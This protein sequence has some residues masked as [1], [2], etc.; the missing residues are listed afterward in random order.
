MAK[1]FSET[2]FHDDAHF[3]ANP[4]HAA[5]RLKVQDDVEKQ[6]EHLSGLHNPFDPTVDDEKYEAVRK[7]TAWSRNTNEY[8]L[9]KHRADGDHEIDYNAKTSAQHEEQ[10]AHISS[11]IKELGERQPLEHETHVYSGIRNF[12][13]E[14]VFHMPA[15]TSTSIDP[16]VANKFGNHTFGKEKHIIHFTLPKG[17]TKG[18]YLGQAVSEHE[19]EHEYLLDKDQKFKLTHKTEHEVTFMHKPIKIHCW[20]VTPVDH[21]QEAFDHTDNDLRLSQTHDSEPLEAKAHSDVIETHKDML[22]HHPADELTKIEHNAVRAHTSKSEGVNS[23]LLAGR[24]YDDIIIGRHIKNVMSAIDKAKPLHRD[25]HVYSGLGGFNPMK[26]ANDGVFHTPAFIST[27]INPQT[28]TA[29]ANH[30][31]KYDIQPTIGKFNKDTDPDHILHVHLPKGYEGGRYIAG[32]SV[33]PKEHEFLLAPN[34]HYKITHVTEMESPRRNIYHA[35]PYYRLGMGTMKESF[36][37]WPSVFSYGSRQERAKPSAGADDRVKTHLARADRDE[38]HKFLSS[39]FEHVTAGKPFSALEHNNEKED[40]PIHNYVF[41]SIAAAINKRCILHHN[42]YQMLKKMKSTNPEHFAEVDKNHSFDEDVGNP[43]PMK[44]SGTSVNKLSASIQENARPL[45]RE[46]HFYSA[47]SSAHSSVLRDTAGKGGVVHLPAFTSTTIDPYL[48]RTWSGSDILHFHLPAGYNK[49][50][51]IGH[52]S[53]M[54]HEYEFLLDKAQD[55]H[56]H[57]VHN[58]PGS[59]RKLWTLKPIEHLNETYEYRPKAFIQTERGYWGSKPKLAAHQTLVAGEVNQQNTELEAAM[60]TVPSYDTAENSRIHQYTNGRVSSAINKHLISG[61]AHDAPLVS[62]MSHADLQDLAEFKGWN[63]DHLGSFTP[64]HLSNEIAEHGAPL[65]HET[66]VYSGMKNFDPTEHF[67]QHG[68][69][70]LPAFT[71]TSIDPYIA[72]GFA[73]HEHEDTHVLHMVVPKGYSKGVYLGKR[74]TYDNEKEY[75]LDKG[76]KWDFVSKRVFKKIKSPPDEWGISNDNLGGIK[77]THVWTVKPHET[78]LHEALTHDAKKYF[79]QVSVGDNF[80]S[81]KKT[82]RVYNSVKKKAH[83]YNSKKT[84]HL[85]ATKE[86][87]T[88]EHASVI[89]RQKG[90]FGHLDHYTQRDYGEAIRGYKGDDSTTFN[91]HLIGKSNHDVGDA[92]VHD[93]VKKSINDLTSAIEHAPALDHETHVYSGISGWDPS[94]HLANGVIHTPAFTSTSFHPTVASGF[95]NRHDTYDGSPSNEEMHILHFHLPAGYKEG[96]AIHGVSGG[97]HDTSLGEQEDD[98][99]KEYV[100]NRGQSWK[101][102]GKQTVHQTAFH[103]VK[104]QNYATDTVPKT[105]RKVHVWTLTPHEHQ[106]PKDIVEAYNHDEERAVL[107]DPSA[108]FKGGHSSQRPEQNRQ[109]NELSAIFPH[110][111]WI[112]GPHARKSYQDY[113]GYSSG[114]NKDLIHQHAGFHHSAENIDRANKLS[115]HIAQDTK[116][117]PHDVHV[118]SGLGATFPTHRIASEGEIHTPAFVSASLNSTVAA[119]FA[120]N[121]A[122]DQ[123]SFHIA[124]FHL[125]AGYTKGIYLDSAPVNE[126]HDWVEGNYNEREYLLDKDQ[127]WKHTGTEKIVRP[128]NSVVHVHSFV[129][130]TDLH[131]ALAGPTTFK[132]VTVSGMNTSRRLKMR[133]AQYHATR[134]ADTSRIRDEA[135]GEM[136]ARIEHQATHLRLTD[137]EDE[138][139]HSY[140]GMSSKMMNDHLAGVETY[141]GNITKHIDHLSRAIDKA[142]PLQH[143]T[144]VYS[145]LSN[146]NPGNHAKVGEVFHTPAFTSTSYSPHVATVFS[147]RS[148]NI[149]GGYDTADDHILHF[150]LP[151]G[152]KGGLA[153]SYTNATSMSSLDHDPEAELILNKGQKWKLTGH[154]VTRHTRF[155]T[156]GGKNFYD[157]DDADH[158]PAQTTKYIKKVHVWHV[159]PHTED[160]KET[161]F[162]DPNVFR[163]TKIS[164]PT[165]KANKPGYLKFART[166]SALSMKVNHD[167]ES[168]H[169]KLANHYHDPEASVSTITSYTLGSS[170][171]NRVLVADRL[172]LYTHHQD[173]VKRLD[174]ELEHLSRKGTPHEMH[175]YSGLGFDPTE[176]MKGGTFHTPAY[177]SASTDPEVAREYGKSESQHIIH[178]HLPKGFKGGTYVRPHSSWEEESEFLLK[179]GQ[180]WKVTNH[181]VVKSNSFNSS[182]YHGDKNP[183]GNRLEVWKRK[184]HVWTVVPHE[185][186]PQPL[187]EATYHDKRAIGSYQNDRYSS[188]GH[189]WDMNMG[190]G[191]DLRKH[192]MSRATMSDEDVNHQHEELKQQLKFKP[193]DSELSH[194][195]NYT[196]SSHDM[197]Q[198]LLHGIKTPINT[199]HS[200]HNEYQQAR[201]NALSNIIA[202]H[203]TEL[204]ADTHV[205]S[206]MKGVRDLHRTMKV[207][208]V[209]H[210]PA[211]T[212]TSLSPRT[213]TGFVQSD[214]GDSQ[215]HDNGGHRFS[216]DS[217]IIHFQLPAGYKKGLYID[218]HSTC[219]GEN[220]YLLDKGQKWKVTGHEIARQNYVSHEHPRDANGDHIP[221]STKSLK[222]ENLTR[223]HIWTVVPH[224]EEHLKVEVRNSKWLLNMSFQKA[225]QFGT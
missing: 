72:R 221:N 129:P 51:Y 213:S 148:T 154:D 150:H 152:Y 98:F 159:E 146:F 57:K 28:A 170:E 178:F 155:V 149:P 60:P 124:H 185:E 195:Q 130:K 2:T 11:Y 31:R 94:D 199:Y 74:S 144:H 153:M 76:S 145:G 33:F 86:E 203:S 141:S 79:Q 21:V 61:G 137:K 126:G 29:K 133:V 16:K 139:V 218:P 23:E 32:S 216:Y 219:Q 59:N 56:V 100:L 173:K 24:G 171:M 172:S 37:H 85:Q 176:H 225:A 182:E 123:K 165:Y 191:Y 192:F 142:E 58:L 212:S 30:L 187:K 101:V 169:D 89:A 70:H 83:L 18:A 99:E 48:S 206:G 41:G 147:N 93:W 17:Y 88:E 224:E 10:S 158:E 121:K 161:T 77:R 164:T 223:H 104:Y 9:S 189:S 27:S 166:Q 151:A 43:M 214:V 109:H 135:Q 114:M 52:K 96:L 22:A 156:T 91:R 190:K 26:I 80:G 102:Q 44:L 97:T 45:S 39:Q 54:D 92:Q 215:Y 3:D 90:I 140:K 69:I 108:E 14:G 160:I 116:S 4:E 105:I 198:Y 46:G 180:K 117:L 217:H 6:D 120:R 25:L 65:P 106:S 7:H 53:L 207:G 62:H 134:G 95:V 42:D 71:S 138:A 201:S 64:N 143:E 175:V 157:R 205:Y 122:S 35:V 211:F 200:E 174:G 84:E 12:V 128:D 186:E 208:D 197:N 68:S 196:I 82:Q 34:Q 110:K 222:F 40:H 188:S 167:V 118:Y 184:V 131:E 136:R 67:V 111:I 66:H 73:N 103:D 183:A 181:Q 179:R 20:H 119:N 193:E 5:H 19:D 38:H 127:M 177:I 81:A 107:K 50:V 162:H 115:A 220:E 8:L 168:E 47:I 194:I 210:T 132:R 209:F 55:F 49:G 163:E 202:K 15:F 113:K 13:P 204:P 87:A 1:L 78:D 63:I 75:L 112:G 36:L 125:P